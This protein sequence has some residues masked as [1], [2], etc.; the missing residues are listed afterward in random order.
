VFAK[1]A[2]KA[3]LSNKKEVYIGGAYEVFG[4]YLKRF[5]PSLVY[6]MV[7]KK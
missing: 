7:R 3:I 4:V 2:M 6:R 5:L 1:K